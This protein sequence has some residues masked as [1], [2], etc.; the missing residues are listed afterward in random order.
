MSP[1]KPVK[2]LSDCSF[3][4][5]ADTLTKFL[6]VKSHKITFFPSFS[7][8]ASELL[9]RVREAK[10]ELEQLITRDIR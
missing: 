2:P 10:E 1:R 8:A 4:L 5:V 7:S 3:S 9:D 6:E